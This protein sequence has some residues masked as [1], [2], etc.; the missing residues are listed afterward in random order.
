M[1]K[2]EWDEA[3]NERNIRERGIPFEFAAEFDFKTALF[4]TEPREKYGESRI[5]ALGFLG[6]RLHVLV[7]TM[8]GESLRVISLRKANAREVRKYAQNCSAESGKG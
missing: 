8:R 3:K 1:W 6:E 7:F 4:V 5:R 2:L